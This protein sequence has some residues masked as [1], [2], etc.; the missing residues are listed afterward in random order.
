MTISNEQKFQ[1]F[2]SSFLFLMLRNGVVDPRN[3]F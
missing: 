3:A 1:K 2:S